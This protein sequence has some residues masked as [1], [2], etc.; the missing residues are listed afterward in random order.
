[1]LAL[2]P[3]QDRNCQGVTRRSLL[4]AGAVSAAGLS[5]PALFQASPAAARPAGS[6]LNVI[7]L[8]L[9][10]GPSQY[11]TFDPKPE[12]AAEIRGPFQPI[13]TTVDGLQFCEHLPRLARLANRF[14]TIRNLHHQNTLHTDSAAYAQS[15]QLPVGGVRPANHGAVITR[16]GPPGRGALPPAIRIGPHLWDCAGEV[17]GQDGGPLGGVYAPFAVEDPRLPLEQ[18][19]SVQLP[20]GVSEGRLGRR[21]G[22]LSQVD[23]LQ[24]RVESDSEAARGAAY[25]RAFSLVT[26]REAKAALDLSREPDAVRDRYGRTLPGQ[27][28]LMARRLIEAGVRFVQVNWCKYVAQQGWDTHGTG[29]NMGGTIPQMKDFLLTALDQTVSALFEDLAQRGLDRNTV[30]IAGGEFGRTAKISNIGGREHW[31]GVYPALLYGGPVPKGLVIGRSDADGMYPDGPHLAPEDVSV[32]LYRLLGME[33]GPEMRAARVV[34][35][36][37]GIPGIDPTLPA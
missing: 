35:D 14:T 11:E 9:W 33:I 37:R 30:V 7:F 12:A 17:V 18:I 28:T 6:D 31:P 26:S 22:L 23:D 8:F 24:R 36:A 4:T 1:M 19:G 5:L 13:G 3:I 29:D 25:E 27:G 15:G 21:R 10:G 20:P 16:F 32:T 34:V 2:G